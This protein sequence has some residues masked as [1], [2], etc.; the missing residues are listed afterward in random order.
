MRVFDQEEKA[1]INKILHGIGYARNLINILDSMSNL[2]STRVQ[3]NRSDR[4]AEY[5]FEIQ[6]NEPTNDEC[7]RGIKRQRELTELINHGSM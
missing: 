4:T 7:N 1:I 6:S 5:L 3:I 2:Q